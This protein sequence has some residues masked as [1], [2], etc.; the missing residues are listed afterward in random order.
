MAEI[1]TGA[2]KYLTLMDLTKRLG[3]KALIKIAEVMAADNPII[4]DMPLLQGNEITGNR[5]AIRNGLPTAAWTK[6]YE[7][8]PPS[9]SDVV[10]VMDTVGTLEAYSEVDKRLYDIAP[11]RGEFRAQEDLA[12]LE[13]M[14]Q[15]VAE[16][17]FYGEKDGRS[18]GGLSMRYATLDEAKAKSARNIINGGGTAGGALTSMWIV[19]WGP[20]TAYSFHGRNSTG[21]GWSR[22]D[23]GEQTIQAPTE[24]EGVM[25]SMQVLRTHFKWELGM[26]VRDYRAIVRIAN[27]PVDN[28]EDVSL[29][30]LLIRGIN[31][32]KAKATGQPI[33]YCNEAIKT[34]LDIERTNKGN[35]HLTLSEFG[36]EEVT[37]IRGIPI[38]M[39]DAL[40][41]SEEVVE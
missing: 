23:L 17:V 25:G 7:G 16:S 22:K 36:G 19:V 33:I 14:S 20:L 28:L 15:K 30:N 6:L 32:L 27:I 5:V 12:F 4:K 34:A 18:F 10:A 3:D 40:L 24:T 37:S 21:A 26:T 8:V 1:L 35:V 13:T 2:S 31:R 41:S 39:C 38:K 29:T 9:K 11:D